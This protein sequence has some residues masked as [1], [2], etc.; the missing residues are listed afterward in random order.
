M[1]IP[2]AAI[3]PIFAAMIAALAVFISTVLSKE[4][5]TSEFRQAWIDELRKDVAQYVSGTIEFAAL[6]S[7]KKRKLEGIDFLAENFDAIR[8][9]QSI[10]YRIIFRLNPIK[11]ASLISKIKGLRLQMISLYEQGTT[12]NELEEAITGAITDDCKI[13][14]KSEWERVKK[15]ESGF[16]LVKWAAMGI[17]ILGLLASLLYLF[18]K[19]AST[20]IVQKIP[21]TIQGVPAAASTPVPLAITTSGQSVNV[22]ISTPT[23]CTAVKPLTTR[24]VPL[25]RSTPEAQVHR[26]SPVCSAVAAKCPSEP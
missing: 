14:L 3:G 7:Q 24:S 23:H 5:K 18:F 1:P 26:D 6:F 16:R 22:N 11:H 17:A 2:D 10:E 8:D 19:P 20:E 4:Q 21:T 12:N 25:P 15:G 9:L 13:I